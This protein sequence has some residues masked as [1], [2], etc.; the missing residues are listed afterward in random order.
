MTLESVQILKGIHKAGVHLLAF[1]SDDKMLVSCGLNLLSAI[2]IY[3]WASGE[4]ITS[5][6]ITSPT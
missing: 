2:I 1:T 6:A 5:T 4:V 3:E